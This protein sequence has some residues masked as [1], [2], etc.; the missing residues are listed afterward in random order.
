MKSNIA[1]IGFMATGKSEVGRALAKKLDRKYVCVD[2]LIEKKT[3]KKLGKIFEDGGEGE[4]RKFESEIVKKASS[5]KNQVI[6]CGGGVVLNWSNVKKLKKTSYVICLTASPEIIL[7]RILRK[8]RD[9]KRPLLSCSQNKLEKIK[10]LMSSRETLYRKAADFLMDTSQLSVGEVVERIAQVMD[11]NKKVIEIEAPPSKSYTNRALI[12]SSLANGA[13]VIKNPCYCDDTEYMIAALREFGVR[14]SKN[15]DNSLTVQGTGGKIKKPKREIF[16]GNSGTAMRFL[17][18]FCVLSGGKCTINGDDRMNERPIQVLLD[19]LNQM[20]ITAYS[21]NKNGCPPVVIE[22]GELSGGKMRIK[23]D[24]S[25]QYVSSLL[26]CAPYAKE[27]SEIEILDELT[28]KPYVDLTTEIM[29]K[30][31]VKVGNEKYRKF[32][33]MNDQRYEGC[34]VTVEGDATNASYFFALAAITGQGIR[35][36]NINSKT[37][38]GDIH[39]VDVLG[40]MGCDVSSGKNWIEVKGGDLKSVEV[41]MN[42]MPDVVQTLAVVALFAKGKTEIRNIENLRIK[43]TDRISALANELRKVGARVVELK[44][45]L[46]IEPPKELNVCEIETY[47]DHRMVMSFALLSFKVPDIRVKNPNCVNK[48]FPE[49]WKVLGKIKNEWKYAG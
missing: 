10:E 46:I 20:G 16:V 41:D 28:S 35:V 39:F 11:N 13:S 6:D 3:G 32:R 29:K 24:I 4:F 1:L 47:K 48:S 30:F 26:M 17:T 22:P 44:N 43:E 45:G 12:I 49:F 14:I 38:Q 31:G 15:R 9:K 42:S 19:A 23:G 8:G 18:T 21:K 25:S 5:E 7:K 27:D 36:A 33:I 2:Y 40:K 34:E 37:S